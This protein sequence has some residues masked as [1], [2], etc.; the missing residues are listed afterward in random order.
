MNVLFWILQT[1]NV[2]LLGIPLWVRAYYKTR[3]FVSKYGLYL[4]CAVVTGISMVMKFQSED[5]HQTLMMV[6]IPIIIVV[7]EN[8]TVRVVKATENNL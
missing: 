8:V 5:G 7:S 3:F 1:I 6:A 2:L 4:I